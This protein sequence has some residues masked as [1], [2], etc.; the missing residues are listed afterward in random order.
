MF[1]LHNAV[2]SINLAR[3]DFFKN[4][5][6][7]ESCTKKKAEILC[8]IEFLFSEGDIRYQGQHLKLSY[9]IPNGLR[10]VEVIQKESEMFSKDASG[11]GSVFNFNEE[12]KHIDDY[13]KKTIV[14]LYGAFS[15]GKTGY[16]LKKLGEIY[17]KD[18]IYVTQAIDNWNIPNYCQ[19]RAVIIRRIDLVKMN[20]KRFLHLVSP[21]TIRIGIKNATVFKPEVIYF[22]SRISPKK[23]LDTEDNIKEEI[24]ND[25]EI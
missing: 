6:P 19:Q 17:R 8:T 2:G 9:D 12:Q 24:E 15:M 20:Y 25:F 18:D 13:T 3:E 7:I 1:Q 10:Q 22:T 16:A 14:F 4:V 5:Q 23:L 21:R 11:L